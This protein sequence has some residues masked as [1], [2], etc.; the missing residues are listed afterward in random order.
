MITK[1]PFHLIVL[2][3]FNIG[4]FLAREIPNVYLLYFVLLL[5][6][7][8]VYFFLK[9]I[10]KLENKTI[11]LL[12]I[13]LIILLYFF[14]SIPYNK[15]V[16][17]IYLTELGG[18]LVNCI[19]NYYHKNSGLLQSI[20]SLYPICLNND[21]RDLAKKIVRY[22]VFYKDTLNKPYK[23]LNQQPI[24]EDFFTLICMKILWD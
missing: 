6:L 11:L 23:K 8:T 15:E 14:I 9:L 4:K 17:L 21:E 19:D 1:I 12:E 10:I 5:S 16:R 3:I 18:K 22:N 7:I 20:D 24:D 2:E 13:I